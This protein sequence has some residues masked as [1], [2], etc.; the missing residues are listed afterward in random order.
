MPRALARV[1]RGRPKG[2]VNYF[3][4]KIKYNNQIIYYIMEKSILNIVLDRIIQVTIGVVGGLVVVFSTDLININYSNLIILYLVA[5]A[6]I[7][8][9]ELRRQQILK[10]NN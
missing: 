10:K 4:I 9:L 5:I 8:F 2:E 6:G 3:F 7:L 1:Q